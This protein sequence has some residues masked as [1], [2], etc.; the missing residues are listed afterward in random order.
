MGGTENKN[1]IA[2]HPEAT[3]MRIREVSKYHGQGIG[4][5]A[6]R[7]VHGIGLDG[8]HAQSTGG[9]LGPARRSSVSITTRRQGA[10]DKVRDEACD[11]QIG[12][13][14]GE[15]GD[16]DEVG[17]DGEIARDA[18][19]GLQLLLGGI[20]VVICGQRSVLNSRD[21]GDFLV[22]LVGSCRQRQYLSDLKINWAIRTHGE[23]L[24]LRHNKHQRSREIA[25]REQAETIV[26]G[27]RAS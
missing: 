10:I 3:G 21:T 9:L 15:L 8:A 23:G 7:L 12:R 11:T 18:A 25:M 16:A 6:E 1:A 2:D 13:A 4:Q 5:H 26:A 17:D 19:Q 27:Q 14:L 20:F 24:G 22:G